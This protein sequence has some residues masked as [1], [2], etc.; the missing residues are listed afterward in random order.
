MHELSAATAILRTVQQ[1]AEGRN[2]RKIT[3]VRVEIGELTLLNPEQLRFC[4]GIAAKDTI[5]EGAELEVEV[6]P[7]T[8]ECSSCGKR[9]EWS[10]PGNDPAYHLVSPRIGCHCGSSDV[11]I[12][13]GRDLKVVNMTVEKALGE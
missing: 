1:T 11:R 3:K 10:M 8:I 9:F 5:A 7:A 12:S 2:A 13:S 6:N 4:F